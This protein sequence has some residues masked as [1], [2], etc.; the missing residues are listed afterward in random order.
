M[1]QTSLALPPSLQ[2]LGRQAELKRERPC[3]SNLAEM[4]LPQTGREQREESDRHENAGE[5]KGP[6]E[7]E[8]G[9]IQAFSPHFALLGSNAM[10]AL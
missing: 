10:T 2:T 7:S 6:G 5:W 1:R 3:A 4:M 8:L 9:A